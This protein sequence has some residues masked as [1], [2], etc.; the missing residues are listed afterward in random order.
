MVK[1][2]NFKNPFPA[3]RLSL[4]DGAWLFSILIID[5]LMI[6]NSLAWSVVGLSLIYLL[7]GL[8]I[9]A[10]F[11]ELEGPGDLWPK[12]LAT[13]GCWLV[14]HIP[15]LVVVMPV[16]AL[17]Q[18]TRCAKMARQEYGDKYYN[19]L[20]T[21]YMRML[22]L[23]VFGMLIYIALAYITAGALQETVQSQ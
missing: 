16:Y 23:S 13:F 14:S 18:Y 8:H 7:L 3:H 20:W 5:L 15:F 19:I 12:R 9:L 11:K 21:T 17:I 4:H 10:Q 22:G 2:F 6:F 1:G